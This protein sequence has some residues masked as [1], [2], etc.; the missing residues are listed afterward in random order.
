M[1]VLNDYSSSYRDLLDKAFK[2]ILHVP[3]LKAIAIEAYK[4][5]VNE[6]PDHINVMLNPL[7]KPYDLRGGPRAEQ[8]TNMIYLTVHLNL[9]QRYM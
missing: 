1:V 9:S 5:K 7:I 6:N 2:P 3:R 4:C 8:L